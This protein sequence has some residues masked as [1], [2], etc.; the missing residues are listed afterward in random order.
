MAEKHRSR[1]HSYSNCSQCHSVSLAFRLIL[2]V[3]ALFL[4]QPH[5]HT[6]TPTI[7]KWSCRN[8][9]KA[10]AASP[11]YRQNWPITQNK[12]VRIIIIVVAECD[13]YY[14]IQRLLCLLLNWRADGLNCEKHATRQICPKRRD[15]S[16]K[17][18]Q[19][20]DIILQYLLDSHKFNRV[21]SSVVHY[22]KQRLPPSGR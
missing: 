6:H 20:R 18:D 9:H 19:L 2:T 7:H 5:T 1:V 17:C 4:Q 13:E 15:K 12:S 3:R 21:Y 22:Q 10:A 8:L 11:D 16:S 14:G